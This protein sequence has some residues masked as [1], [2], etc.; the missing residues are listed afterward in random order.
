M[1]RAS[2]TA[3]RAPFSSV[4]ICTPTIAAPSQKRSTRTISVAAESKY[5][6]APSPTSVAYRRI[7]SDSANDL[8]AP[9]TPEC[10]S[11]VIPC[12]ITTARRA[13]VKESF[14]RSSS[15]RLSLIASLLVR[16]GLVLWQRQCA[17]EVL[18]G[19]RRSRQP[20]CHGFGP[21]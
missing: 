12:A 13:A 9:S 10:R 19:L 3:S 7:A 21:I 15:G 17:P 5:A 18:D 2:S 20:F 8:P 6:A 14:T 1:S 11:S 4:E 16:C